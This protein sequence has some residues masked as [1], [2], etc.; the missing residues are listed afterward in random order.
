MKHN[1]HNLG[2]IGTLKSI[3]EELNSLHKYNKKARKEAI[4]DIAHEINFLITLLYKE[5]KRKMDDERIQR[6]IDEQSIGDSA[7]H[8]KLKQYIDAHK[9]VKEMIDKAS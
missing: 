5:D 3:L 2:K 9:K 8:E 4:Q 1:E 7:A 6:A